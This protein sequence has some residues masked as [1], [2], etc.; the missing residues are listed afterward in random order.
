MSTPTWID[1]EHGPSEGICPRCGSAAQFTYTAEGRTQVQVM[2]PDCG[3]F[4]VD[5]VEFDLA[6]TEISP[7]DEGEF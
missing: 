3:R 2:C 6:E 1:K 4:S 5:R 7:V